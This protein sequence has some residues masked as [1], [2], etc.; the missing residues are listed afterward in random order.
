MPIISSNLTFQINGFFKSARYLF[1][2]FA[3]ESKA[4]VGGKDREPMPDGQIVYIKRVIG[5][6]G[7]TITLDNLPPPDTKRWV[8]RRKAEVVAAVRGGVLT[9]EEACERYTLSVE[10]FASWQRMVE[11]HG[12]QGLRTTRL[13]QYRN[14]DDVTG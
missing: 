9:L 1:P 5:P 2:Q 13:Q 7:E 3:D 10:E 12:L 8:A 14:H 11:A 4:T 6:T